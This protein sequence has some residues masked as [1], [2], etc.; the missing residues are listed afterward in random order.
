VSAYELAAWDAFEEV[1][2][3]LLVH[4]RVDFAGALISTLLANINAPQGRRFDVADFLPHW[5]QPVVKQ[6]DTDD[7]IAFMR[8]FVRKGDS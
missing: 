1:S 7:M 2:G 4:E 3:P 6:Q 5:D 8:T